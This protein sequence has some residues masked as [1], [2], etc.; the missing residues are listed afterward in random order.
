[1]MSQLIFGVGVVS[2]LLSLGCFAVTIRAFWSVE[3]VSEGPFLILGLFLF[4]VGLFFCWLGRVGSRYPKIAVV[5]RA[6]PAPIADGPDR[7]RVV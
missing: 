3:R 6:A 1:M 2:V 7:F 4:F 5:P